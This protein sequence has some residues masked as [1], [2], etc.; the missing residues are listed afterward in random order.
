MEYL[1]GS[2]ITI[3]TMFI[4]SR[5]MLK[6]SSGVRPM[7]PVYTQSRIHQMTNPFINISMGQRPMDTQSSRHFMDNSTKIVMYKSNAY[8]IKDN[9]VYSADI[10]DGMIQEESTKTVDIMSMDRVQLDEMVYI[11]DMLTEGA[12]N[13]NGSSGNQEL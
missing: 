12:N 13:E 9:T 10:L 4:V 2:I 6:N 8:W 7:R 1:I 3:S 11:I 5:T